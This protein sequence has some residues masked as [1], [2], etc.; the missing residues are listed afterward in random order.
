MAVTVDQLPLATEELGLQTVG[1]VLA[2]L[3]KDNRVIV[4]VYIDG[5]S[6][7][8]RRIKSIKR[9]PIAGHTIDI[10]TADPRQI[11]H[12]VL[13]EVEAQLVEADRLTSESAALLQ[14][15]Q[16]APAV[17]KLGGCFTAWR[18]AQEAIVKIAQLRR[19]DIRSIMVQGRA[20]TELLSDFASQLR[21]LRTAL[22]GRDFITLGDLLSHKMNQ[23]AEQWRDAIRS[24]R[25]VI[26]V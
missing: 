16:V 12:Q 24:F 26:C 11:A 4:N 9:S 3:R 2:H 5:Q 13:D 8:I 7:D 14:K 1:Q 17:E 6:P 23:V 18:H 15:K 19:V 22:D 25:G 10:E 21:Q 20:F